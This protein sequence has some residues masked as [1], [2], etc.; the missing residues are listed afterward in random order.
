MRLANDRYTLNS[1]HIH[2]VLDGMVVYRRLTS[3]RPTSEYQFTAPVGSETFSGESSP[4]DGAGAR[5]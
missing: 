1:K 4:W 5:A 2:D 3:R